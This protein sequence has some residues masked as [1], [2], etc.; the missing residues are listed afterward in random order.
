M[1]PF[2]ITIALFLSLVTL[3]GCYNNYEDKDDMTEIVVDK[4]IQSSEH[5]KNAQMN[6][7]CL[8]K[9]GKVR[10]V[11]S[12]D[13]TSGFYPG[14]LWYAYELSDDN[15]LKKAAIAHTVLL[16]NEKNNHTTH[17]M[18]FKLYCSYGNGYRLT[19]NEEF[20]QV[21]LEG[22]KTLSSR[23]NKTTGCIRSWDHHKSQ[24]EFPVIID[25]MMNLE[26]LFWAFTQT[27]DSTYYKI[28]VSHADHTLKNHFRPD[29]SSYHVVDYDTLTGKVIKRTT[30]QGYSDSSA[31]ARGQAW[32]LYGFTMA[33]RFTKD[34]RYLQQ[35][36]HIAKFILNNKNLPEDKIPYWDFDAPK[37]PN[38]PRDAS[39][40]AIISS[41]LF[42]LSEYAP[43]KAAYYHKSAS[44]I[45]SSLYKHY[46]TS[47]T[48]PEGYFLLKHSTGNLP[49]GSE[50]DVPI[51]YADYYFLE[52]IVRD[53]VIRSLIN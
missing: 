48:P 7:R 42:E 13:W 27:H 53:K 47:D 34:V 16:E 25:N 52:A 30:H 8:E 2:L 39:A 1:K 22:A 21:L 29:Y 23:F 40:A 20:R 4:V 31:W 38:E 3:N 32:G 17:D 6:P 24:W 50:I 18:G 37:I 33:Y 41:A 36:E 5:F 46:L 11:A 19:K 9:D 49:A 44:Q 51:I 26:L 15:E 14:C 35:A 43:E 10:M 12:R 45:L 28:A